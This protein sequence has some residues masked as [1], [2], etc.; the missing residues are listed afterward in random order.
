[1]HVEVRWRCRE[2]EG[3][4]GGVRAGQHSLVSVVVTT[5]I[6]MWAGR[7][8]GN[9]AHCVG[10][11]GRVG[12]C[13]ARDARVGRRRERVV[14]VAWKTVYR[15]RLIQLVKVRVCGPGRDWVV[16]GSGPQGSGTV[17][18]LGEREY[19]ALREARVVEMK[20]KVE[21][22]MAAKVAVGGGGERPRSGMAVKPSDVAPDDG[23]VGVG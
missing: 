13:L 15:Q 1:M 11:R 14:E 20:P 23:R 5:T 18:S 2:G 8:V 3:C 22:S 19:L 16:R 10:G 7:W 17:Q 12:C 21:W 9:V 4:Q 6:R